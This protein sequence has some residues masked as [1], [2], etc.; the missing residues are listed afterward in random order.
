M[1][2]SFTPPPAALCSFCCHLM[3]RDRGQNKVQGAEIAQEQPMWLFPS[4]HRWEIIQVRQGWE[5]GLKIHL[6][7]GRD[8]PKG[9]YKTMQDVC[10][11][12]VLFSPK[13]WLP[14]RQEGHFLEISFTSACQGQCVWA[15]TEILTSVL[16]VAEL[17][18]QAGSPSLCSPWGLLAFPCSQPGFQLLPSC[19]PQQG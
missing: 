19:C 9:L 4:L 7:C 17:G 18:S 10:G 12:Y 16:G 14:L 15:R 5:M 11:K 8:G 13:M 1:V 6:P 2:C 3:G